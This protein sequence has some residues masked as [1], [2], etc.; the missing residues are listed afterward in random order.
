LNGNANR[1]FVFQQLLFKY[2][3]IRQ[4]SNTGGQENLSAEI[5]KNIPIV[6]PTLLEQRAIAD[7]LS[8][9]DSAIEKTGRLIEFKKSKINSFLSIVNFVKRKSTEGLAYK[10]Y[11]GP[12]GRIATSLKLRFT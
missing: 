3:T 9:W 7:L 5:I 12:L 11:V 6:L 2:Q 1:D 4:L 8:T 10:L